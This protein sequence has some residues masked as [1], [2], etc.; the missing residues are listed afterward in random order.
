MD[1][2]KALGTK[3]SHDLTWDNNCLELIKK[4]EWKNATSAEMH[5]NWAK[6]QRDGN[7]LDIVL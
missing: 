6:Q 5:R 1:K 7:A 2:I 4:S 3:I